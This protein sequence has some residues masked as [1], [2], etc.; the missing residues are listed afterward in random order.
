MKNKTVLVTG[1]TDGIGKQTVLEMAQ[2]GATVIL[3]G[4]DPAKG[5]RV[6]QE[7][8]EASHNEQLDIFIAN[9]ASLNQV[10]KMSDEIHQKY[11]RLDVLINNA[12]VALGSYEVSED[13]YEMTF[14]VN[15]LAG[16][17][18]TTL[19]LDLIKTGAP[20]RIINV[21]SMVHSSRLDF[22]NLSATKHFD[23][24][25]AYCQSKLCNILFTYEL[26]SKLEGRG[27]TVNCL[28]PGV[29]N[30]KLLRVNFRGGSPVTEGSNKLI[31]LA[32][33]PEFENVTGKY[34][35][36]KRATR[37]SEIT[38]DSEIRKKLWQLSAKLCGL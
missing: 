38:Y 20:S 13:G 10:R 2:L 14:A 12:G 27:V 30:T 16:F 22:D 1:S 33:D 5:H 37:S 32:T 18:L 35:V 8:K 28:H 6:M 36:D 3:H 21:S 9:L 7:I 31:Y 25:E 15:Y 29:I 19:L 11:D 34:F 17:L 26:A 4:R 23:G 24:W